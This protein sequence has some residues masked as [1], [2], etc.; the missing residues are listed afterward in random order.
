MLLFYL[1]PA[2]KLDHPY[3]NGLMQVSKA[4]GRWQAGLEPWPREGLA[5]IKGEEILLDAA[6]GILAYKVNPLASLLSQRLQ[7]RCLEEFRLSP[8]EAD[9]TIK[10]QTLLSLLDL[11]PESN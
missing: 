4:V 5:A 1:D 8:V 7:P 9:A 3:S 6:L 11:R 10:V 2:N